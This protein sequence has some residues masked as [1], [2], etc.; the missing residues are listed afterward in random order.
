MMVQSKNNLIL[1]ENLDK[2]FFAFYQMGIK[3][4]NL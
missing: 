1:N 3:F 4:L 2:S